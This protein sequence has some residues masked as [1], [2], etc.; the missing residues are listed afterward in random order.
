MVNAS[1]TM[2]KQEKQVYARED[3]PF[4]PMPGS[5]FCEACGKAATN[6]LH[7]GNKVGIFQ[8]TPRGQDS[9]DRRAR[10]HRALDA[11]L[12]RSAAR[13]ADN[14]ASDGPCPGMPLSLAKND[15]WYCKHQG[16]VHAFRRGRYIESFDSLGQLLRAINQGFPDSGGE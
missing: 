16:E 14:R 5:I 13:D 6:P 15:I 10:L 4:E 1:R 3:H 7:Y 2:S 11:V 8:S 9:T 12:D